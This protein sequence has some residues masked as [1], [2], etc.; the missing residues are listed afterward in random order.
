LGRKVRLGA[1]GPASLTVSIIHA[2]EGFRE[3]SIKR[4]AIKS[5]VSGTAR[6]AKKPGAK[7]AV[8]RDAR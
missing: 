1:A 5:K 2:W 7:I 4:T 8:K 6:I 3:M